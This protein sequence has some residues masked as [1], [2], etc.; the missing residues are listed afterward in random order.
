M[1]YNNVNISKAD[2]GYVVSCYANEGEEKVVAKT[3]EEALAEAK[4]M[5]SKEYKKENYKDVKA[6]ANTLAMKK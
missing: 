4:K 3:M 6:K 2:N 5:L 1:I